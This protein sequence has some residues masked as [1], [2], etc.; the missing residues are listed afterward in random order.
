MAHTIAARSLDSEI[1]LVGVLSR[2]F[3]PAITPPI[4]RLMHGVYRL[5][6]RGGWHTAVTDCREV[7]ANR[8]DGTQMRML[9]A[10]P[11][12]P[13]D[14]APGL[15]WIH[16]G[17][18]E[19]GIPEMERRYID[20]FVKLSGCTVVSP[21]YRTSF[22]APYPAA[23]ED[24]YTALVWLKDHADRLGYRKDQLFVGGES[25]GGGLAAAVTLLAR[26][27]GEVNVAFQMP[28]YPMLD[29]RHT[30]SSAANDAPVWNTRSNDGAWQ[31]YLGELYGTDDVPYTAA[32]SRCEDVRGLPPLCTIVGTA[33]PFFCETKAYAEKLSEAGIPVAFRAFDGGFHTFETVCPRAKISQDA[34]QFV[35]DNVRIAA[36]RYVAAND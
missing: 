35:T 30:D 2:T 3:L 20:L 5:S 36:K 18:Y 34:I 27:I 29:D 26:D 4:A 32:P 8:A 16:G 33:E 23:L 12:T 13:I 28:L 6:A 1:R 17:G 14:D 9:V 21:D 7:F 19:F 24:C 25:A 22:E 15:L 10:T 11:K 31:R